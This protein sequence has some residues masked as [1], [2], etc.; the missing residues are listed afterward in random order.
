MYCWPHQTKKP[1]TGWLSHTW[2]ALK[3][4]IWCAIIRDR[5]GLAAALDVW[6]WLHPFQ[7]R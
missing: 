3:M 1:R 6:N 7:Q 4:S 5:A 2:W